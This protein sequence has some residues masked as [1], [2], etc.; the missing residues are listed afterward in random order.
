MFEDLIDR[1]VLVVVGESEEKVTTQIGILKEITEDFLILNAR[2][3][4][5]AIRIDKIIK[6]KERSA[7]GDADG[8]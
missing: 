4:T 8:R 6:V 1:E 7:G 3:S 2:G 5:I